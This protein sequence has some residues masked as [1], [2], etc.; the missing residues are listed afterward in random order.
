MSSFIEISIVSIF[1]ITTFSF[2]EDCSISSFHKNISGGNKGTRLT[3]NFKFFHKQKRKQKS[4]IHKGL[5]FRKNIYK[6]NGFKG[7][8]LKK[9]F[10]NNGVEG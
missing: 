9:T 5:G 4:N 10:T 3:D 6:N 1:P 7:E 2:A 8:V